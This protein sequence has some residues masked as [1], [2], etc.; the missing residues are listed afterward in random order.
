MHLPARLKN[1]TAV[2]ATLIAVALPASAA[3]S[4]GTELAA[5]AAASTAC[6]PAEAVRLAD[7]YLRRFAGAPNAADIALRRERALAAANALQRSDVMLVRQAFVDAGAGD[8]AALADVR[9]AAVGDRD[10]IRRIAER[11]QAQHNPR[12]VG[13]LQYGA[14]LGD[15][16]AAYALALHYRRQDQP[17][18]AQVYESRALAMGY[19]PPPALAHARK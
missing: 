7:D 14:Q 8:A 3:E 11:A 16:E 19:Q 15:D 17:L 9:L 6:W 10:A 4:A 13:W 18:L 1:A 12:Y 5:R 2:V